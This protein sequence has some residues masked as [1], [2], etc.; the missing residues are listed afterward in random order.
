[1][2]FPMIGK[3]LSIV[4]KTIVANLPDGYNEVINWGMITYEVSAGTDFLKHIMI[5]LL[6][7]QH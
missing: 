4:R 6:C 5:N 7:M 2:N 3:S 1:M